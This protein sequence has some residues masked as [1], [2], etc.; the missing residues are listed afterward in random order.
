MRPGSLVAAIAALAM[1]GSISACGSSS[2]DSG[3]TESQTA[4]QSF[5]IGYAGAIQANPNNKAVEDGIKIQADSLGMDVIV[6]DANLD[7]NKQIADVESL[8]AQGVDAIIIWPLDPNGIQAALDKARQANIPIIVQDTPD[9][10]DVTSNFQVNN[11]ESAKE[12]AALVAQTVG[13]GSEVGII[14]GLPVVGVLIARN[15][16][17]AVGAQESG[18]KIVGQQVNDKD[19][20][21]GARPIADAWKAKYGATLKGI[22]AYNDPSALGAASAIG[23]DFTPVVVGINGDAEGVAA[24]KDGRLL[25]TFDFMPVELGNGL[26]WGAHQILTGN[27]LPAQ[28]NFE[29]TLIDSSNAGAWTSSA[30]RLLSPMKV[31]IEERDGKS[32]LVVQ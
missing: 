16:G 31:G 5:T 15:E 14:E 6:T 11:F 22:L 7:P 2:S 21:D 9:A 27:T 3:A 13:E 28:V 12:A 29:M 4:D 26:A 23:G 20:A 8:V 10:G 30:D 19:S 24:V 18:L 25:A 1:V 32:Y 17:F